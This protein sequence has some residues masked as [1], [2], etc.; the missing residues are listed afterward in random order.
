MIPSMLVLTHCGGQGQKTAVRHPQTIAPKAASAQLPGLPAFVVAQVPPGT[1]G[2]VVTSRNDAALAVWAE[3]T[4][5]GWHFRS[6]EIRPYTAKVSPAVDLGQAPE[7]LE[8]LYLRYL[9][10]TGAILAYTHADDNGGHRFSAM[11]L[12]E[13]GRARSE[14]VLLGVSSEALL[15][16]DI[17]STNNGPL[18]MWASS[19][20]DRADVRAAALGRDGTVRSAAHDVASD[21]RAWQVAPSPRGAVLATVRA[22]STKSNGPIS[23]LFLDDTGKVIEKAVSVTQSESAELDLDVSTV[24]NNCVVA[25]TDRLNGDA[26]LYA[27]AVSPSGQS[28]P[29]PTR[30]PHP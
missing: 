7:D 1:Q 2:P 14:P 29:L 23:L 16:I 10:D 30:L 26:R 22:V 13:H 21:L 12:D 17:V 15:W 8:L 11:L 9:R 20:G 27:A 6:E 28:F 25:W 3:S 18:V 4:V 5:S 19:R 24:G